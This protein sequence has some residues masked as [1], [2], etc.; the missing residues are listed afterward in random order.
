MLRRTHFLPVAIA[1]LVG[2]ACSS[3]DSVLT[4][5]VV[6]D[7]HLPASADPAIS[8]KA[9]APMVRNLSNREY[10]NAVSDL[11]GERLSADLVKTWTATTQFAGFDSVAWTNYDGKALR[12]RTETLELILDKAV[13]SKTLFTCNAVTGADLVYA[14]CAKTILEPLAMRAF[15]R[16]LTEVEAA[17]LAKVYEEAITLAKTAMTEPPALL[18]EGIRAALGSILIAPQLLTRVEA[19]PTPMFTGERDLTAFEIANRI[20]F[21]FLNSIPDEQLWAK[22]LDGSLSKPEVIV[23]EVNRLIDTKTDLFVQNFMGQWFEFRAYDTTAPT[24]IERAMWNESWLT[25]ADVVKGDLPPASIVKPGFTYMNQALATHYGLT[26]KFTESFTKLVTSDRGGV[27]QQGAW[28]SLSASPL[29]TSPMHR[30]RL[31]QDRLLCKEIPPP[32][33][34]LFAAI[35]AASEKIPATASVKERLLAH[36][37]AGEA[38]RR[39]HEYMDPIGLGLEG[40]DQFGKIRTMYSDGKPVESA[41]DILGKPFETVLE[42]SEE[43]AVLPEYTTCVAEKL[44]VFALRTSGPEKELLSYVTH[45]YDKKQPGVREMV[46]RMVQSNAFRRVEHRFTAAPPPAADAGPE[47]STDGGGK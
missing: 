24:S 25:L 21:M 4:D 39:C 32:D 11:I 6:G 34:S 15:G 1:A 29:K 26:G 3:P 19:P 41:S 42:L 37:S 9:S 28:L 35:Q 12:D 46:L 17:S 5:D 23:A 40:F 33:S 16:P 38:C 18:K 8:V 10:L 27:L 13:A 14:T 22:A 43:I 36:R 7:D 44:A 2:F 31:V 20:S 45:A 30:G 47:M